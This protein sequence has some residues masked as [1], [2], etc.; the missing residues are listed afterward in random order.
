[1]NVSS[2]NAPASSPSA[3]IYATELSVPVSSQ[4][5]GVWYRSS[6]C[7][8]A[9]TWEARHQRLTTYKRGP[10]AHRLLL[11]ILQRRPPVPCCRLLLLLH[12]KC[13]A[14]AAAFAAAM[15]FAVIAVCVCVYEYRPRT[16]VLGIPTTALGIPTGLGSNRF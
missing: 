8:T 14:A 6:S 11:P 16:I 10:K 5:G 9:G 2:W 15:R 4:A 1:V 3:A 13:S 12:A 7:P